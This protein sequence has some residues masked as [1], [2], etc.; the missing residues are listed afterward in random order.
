M[1]LLDWALL[2]VW[3][4]VTLGGFWKG[5]VR[6]VF[7]GG[8]L[9][10]GLWLAVAAGGDAAAA[11]ESLIGIEWLAEVLGLVCQHLLS[12]AGFVRRRRLVVPD[13][14]HADDQCKCENSTH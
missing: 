4:G 10:V 9:I 7:G 3:L 6:I 8:G 13:G 1:T 11:M 12:G 5:A 14:H 2:L